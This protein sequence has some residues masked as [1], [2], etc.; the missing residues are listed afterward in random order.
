MLRIDGP[1]PSKLSFVR[2]EPAFEKEGERELI[3]ELPED[4]LLHEMIDD[5]KVDLC[6]L[7]LDE[8]DREVAADFLVEKIHNHLVAPRKLKIRGKKIFV[9]YTN[10]DLLRSV[11]KAHIY[12][13]KKYRGLEPIRYYEIVGS[14]VSRFI[15]DRIE[16]IWEWVG[17][18]LSEEVKNRL[19]SKKDDVDHRI[20]VKKVYS[21]GLRPYTTKMISDLQK[22]VGAGASIFEEGLTKRGGGESGACR[23]LMIGLGDRISKVYQEFI[24]IQG[25]LDNVYLS[26]EDN[27]RIGCS[28]GDAYTVTLIAEENMGPQALI[29]Q[30]LEIFHLPH[31][32]SLGGRALRKIILK[33]VQGKRCFPMRPGK[34]TGERTVFENAIQEGGFHSLWMHFID[35]NMM[36]PERVLFTLL[37]LVLK[38]E[39][40]GLHEDCTYFLDQIKETLNSEAFRKTNGF[41]TLIQEALAAKSIDSLVRFLN[42]QAFLHRM[43]TDERTPFLGEEGTKVVLTH[44]QI[45]QFW[46]ISR[47]GSTLFLP[48]LDSFDLDKALLLA[49][50]FSRFPVTVGQYGAFPSTPPIPAWLTSLRPFTNEFPDLIYLMQVRSAPLTIFA[51]N[52]WELLRQG[53]RSWIIDDLKRNGPF[54][55]KFL[56]CIRRNPAKS[57]FNY[58][59][60]LEMAAQ[61]QGQIAFLL[62]EQIPKDQRIANG[63]EH[64]P[65]LI[66]RS[67]HKG[68]EDWE[69]AMNSPLDEEKKLDWT[70]SLYPYLSKL[71]EGQLKKT[72]LC[73]DRLA[74]Q[75]KERRAQWVEWIK[76]GARERRTETALDVLYRLAKE[77]KVKLKSVKKTIEALWLHRFNVDE[78][79]RPR[80]SLQAK[81]V[82]L[83]DKDHPAVLKNLFLHS[84]NSCGISLQKTIINNYAKLQWTD[85]DRTK[86]MEWYAG[87]IEDADPDSLWREIRTSQM[88]SERQKQGLLIAIH[89]EHN[90][91]PLLFRHIDL[92]LVDDRDLH[93]ISFE[94]C[95]KEMK[96]CKNREKTLHTIIAILKRNGMA[97]FPEALEFFHLRFNSALTQNDRKKALYFLDLLQMLEAKDMALLLKYD[98]FDYCQKMYR[99]IREEKPASPLSLD[100]FMDNLF[101]KKYGHGQFVQIGEEILKNLS[102][103]REAAPHILNLY[104]AT[105]PTKTGSYLRIMLHR[106][107]ILTKLPS[108][109]VEEWEEYIQ[110]LISHYIPKNEESC[111]LFKE[112]WEGFIEEVRKE[113]F[114]A[115]NDNIFTTLILRLTTIIRVLSPQLIFS[116]LEAPKLLSRIEVIE[117]P[118]EHISVV[119]NCLDVFT[120]SIHSENDSKKRH[121]MLMKHVHPRTFQVF[122]EA[123]QIDSSSSETVNDLQICI[124]DTQF[125]CYLNYLNTCIDLGNIEGIE[126]SLKHLEQSVIKKFSWN[127]D[128]VFFRDL[129]E[130]FFKLKKPHPRMQGILSIIL[131]SY[132]MTRNDAHPWPKEVNFAK[133]FQ[134]ASYSVDFCNNQGLKSLFD[135][136][137][138]F[139][140]QAL[141]SP[142]LDPQLRLQCSLLVSRVA[143]LRPDRFQEKLKTIMND[144]HFLEQHLEFFLLPFNTL[145]NVDPAP[146]LVNDGLRWFFDKIHKFQFPV[147]FHRMA[148]AK[149]L[150]GSE[151]SASCDIVDFINVIRSRMIDAKGNEGEELFF[152]DCVQWVHRPF[153][154]ELLLQILDD[155]MSDDHE[156]ILRVYPFCRK[157]GLSID[158]KKDWK[159]YDAFLEKVCKKLLHL[160]EPLR[161]QF[162]RD[163]E[164]V[165]SP[166]LFDLFTRLFLNESGERALHDEQIAEVARWKNWMMKMLKKEG[167]K[168][169]ADRLIPTI[170]HFLLMLRKITIIC[171]GKKK[172]KL[173]ENVDAILKRLVDLMDESSGVSQ[174]VIEMFVNYLYFSDDDTENRPFVEAY[175]HYI[176]RS[177]VYSTVSQDIFVNNLLTVFNQIDQY[178]IDDPRELNYK[179]KVLERMWKLPV[180]NDLNLK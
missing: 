93:S 158:K 37:T 86:L 78:T 106:F 176:N 94:D 174:P 103:Y 165:S 5:G 101:W 115:S 132:G 27:L 22:K 58:A 68:F 157:I 169:A 29:C 61:G 51:G 91:S 146:G 134:N 126:F 59:L 65:W 15:V 54:S 173:A 55:V 82:H 75:S 76:T 152:E 20:P 24:F 147:E 144:D 136:A 155:L 156:S 119:K 64:L 145:C 41:V 11:S 71:S 12:K 23:Q 128:K 33:Q 79:A 53:N 109:S 95:M 178:L 85:E 122:A 129:F 81:G 45:G 19:G 4:R 1:H 131:F 161:K 171:E 36:H 17:K 118:S 148:L 67:V 70:N 30:I 16:E 80:L 57:T 150:K 48:Y 123:S 166:S 141:S 25:K 34:E 31:P 140:I 179:T 120:I 6:G 73:L 83:I 107:R 26:T 50:W 180:L 98:A 43:K 42:I 163:P 105:D 164:A 177:N 72:M 66:S 39:E 113:R 46:K 160:S 172:N 137:E 135:S 108:K 88:M 10:D 8:Y 52:L 60:A 90:A 44:N 14:S 9:D 124:T 69:A 77:K 28:L 18:Y 139:V 125:H 151:L 111:Q 133:A 110:D 130:V 121:G 62:L 13:G 2:P 114:L 96:R 112:I 47:N 117:N 92:S 87:R 127:A 40:F 84:L 7:L 49:G 63:F 143:T 159:E 102:F 168:N 99:M 74:R 142:D 138:E 21:S 154:E 170:N 116:L 100:H 149:L 56:E 104:M 32:E 3:G 153:V 167:A 97:A 35:K 162:I 175:T 89:R 38:L